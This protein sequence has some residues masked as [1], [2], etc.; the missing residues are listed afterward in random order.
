MAF[1][2]V[3]LREAAARRLYRRSVVTGQ[4]T[5]PAVPGMLDEYVAMCAK[6]F[7][8][9]G[10]AFTDE[11]LDHVREVLADQLTR[12]YTES[13]RSTIVISYEAPVGAVLNYLVKAEWWTVEGAY[14]H[15]IGTREPPLFGSEPDALVWTLSSE[16]IDPPTY[17][18]LDIGG[19]TGR[20]ALALARR[21]HP[22]DVVE[23]TP[24]FAELI[25]ADADREALNVRVIQRDV[26]DGVD[27]LRQDYQLIV[28]SE[29]VSDF[30]TTQQ[31]R[32]VF[33]LAARCLMPG[34][35]LVFNAFLACPG[36][37]P[38]NAARE[39]GQQVYT[40]IFTRDELASAAGLLP[41]A[42]VGD[43]SVYE[44][45]KTHLPDGAWPPTSWYADWVSGL[46]V[47]DVERET[48]PIEMRWL[49]YQKAG[50]G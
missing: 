14:E 31:L 35:R 42:L 4:V 12:A 25:R 3:V 27:D 16:A 44:Y 30:R 9:V 47:F 18:V 21:G 19:G 28:L 23:L 8:G 32:G 11:E 24:K 41:L 5:L 26:F 39:L 38:D 22:V 34:G 13:T 50:S 33:E 45:E 43:D 7:A 1:D 36:Y 49:V 2:P 15:W 17:P 46:D 40:T 10:R 6:L 20:N 48:S 37:T 29:V